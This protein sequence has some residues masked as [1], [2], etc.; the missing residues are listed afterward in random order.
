MQAIP[1]VD[2]DEALAKGARAMLIGHLARDVAV[3]GPSAP[4]AGL[5]EAML[6]DFGPDDGILPLIH[7]RSK[8]LGRKIVTKT[9]GSW[10]AFGT[11]FCTCPAAAPPPCR[12]DTIRLDCSIV[13]RSPR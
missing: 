3:S 8:S 6:Q 10:S 4:Q 2:P 12:T 5:R 9:P 13:D 11:L 7:R 1:A